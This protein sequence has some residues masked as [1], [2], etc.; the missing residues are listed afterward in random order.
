MNVVL[1]FPRAVARRAETVATLTAAFEDDPAVRT[2]YPGDADHI[3]YFPGLMH[4]LG[5]QAFELGAVDRDAAGQGA[6]LWLPPGVE[7]DGEAL[8]DFLEASI[9]PAR[10][11]P[12]A[13][14]MAIQSRLHPAEPH[15]YL[16]WI[17]VRPEVQGCGFGTRLLRRGLAR[18]DAE[19]MPCYLEATSR[20][21]VMLYARHG[22]EVIGVVRSP[23]YP[24]IIALWRN[25]LREPFSG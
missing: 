20:R 10:L 4:A 2:L 8:A 22:F 17:G 3:R 6:A 23:G 5:G 7:P 12:I 19:G 13:A 21:N 18:A 1:E 9:P 11:G 24:E 15:W 25:G 16:P 14:G